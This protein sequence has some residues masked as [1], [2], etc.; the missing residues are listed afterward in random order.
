ME[1]QQPEPPDP[2]DL[3]R[4]PRTTVRCGRCDQ[5]LDKVVT[6]G[7]GE[8][9]MTAAELARPSGEVAWDEHARWGVASRQYRCSCGAAPRVTEATLAAAARI[10]RRVVVDADGAVRPL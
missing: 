10:S 8:H 7:D 2:H 5:R 9:V 1:S 4:A 6:F 3:T